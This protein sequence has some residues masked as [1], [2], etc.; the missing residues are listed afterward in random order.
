MEFL[1]ERAGATTSLLLIE[2]PLRVT[3]QVKVKYLSLLR[4]FDSG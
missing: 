3:E 4:V 2:M 1:P